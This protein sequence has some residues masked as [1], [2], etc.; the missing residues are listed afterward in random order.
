MT[1]LDDIIDASTDSAVATPDLLRKVQI[2]THRLGAVDL[3]NWAKQELSGYEESATLP[4]YRMLTTNVMGT[5]AGPMRSFM[6]HPLTLRPKSMAHL[7]QVEFR[8]PIL[9]IQALAEGTNDAAR[10]WSSYDVEEYEKSGV[11][12]MQMHHLFEAQNVITRQSLRG[13]VDTVRSKVLEFAL[14]LQ[15]Q[16]PDAGLAGGP[17]VQTAPALAT[18]VYN[19]TNNVTGHGTNIAAGNQIEQ[20]SRVQ[21]GDSAS[22]K[23]EA[24]ALGLA[25]A[26]ADEFVAIVEENRALDA[27]RLSGFLDKVRSGAIAVSGSLASNVVA[28]ALIELA[29]GF[30]GIQ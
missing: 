18:T 16:F 24:E 25:A 3:V 7:W 15:T 8:E 26:D 5:Y 20:R 28:G 27:P 1:L 23:R 10:P 21:I 2:V 9:E 17:T 6:K 19:I 14:D 12:R 11:F 13:L 29:K 22:L 4:S 30:L